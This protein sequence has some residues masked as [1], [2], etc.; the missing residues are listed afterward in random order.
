MKYQVVENIKWK[1][2]YYVAGDILTLVGEEYESLKGLVRIV[3]TPNPLKNES[4]TTSKSAEP[5]PGGPKP[6]RNSKRTLESE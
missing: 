1:N 6:R 5:L 4:K 3:D 2:Q